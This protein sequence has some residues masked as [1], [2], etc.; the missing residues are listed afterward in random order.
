M[1]Q[2]I[3]EY[4]F[5]KAFDDYNRSDNFSVAGRN[6]LYRYL[7]DL[8][9]DCGIA[10]ELDVI[11]LCCEYCEYDSF[12]ELQEGHDVDDMDDLRD[13]TTVIDVDGGGIIIQCY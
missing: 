7:C 10:I 2:T 11:A 6:A 1:K 12:D 5:V 3:N 8:E 9:E 13:N 4:E